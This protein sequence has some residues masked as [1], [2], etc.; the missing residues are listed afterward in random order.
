[1]KLALFIALFATTV[2]MSASAQVTALYNPATGSIALSHLDSLPFQS[3]FWVFVLKSEA[4]RLKEPGTPIGSGFT[5]H[6]GDLPGKINW[7]SSNAVLDSR[8]FNM[9]DVV[10]PGTS[11]E[12]LELKW[13]LGL[14]DGPFGVL[15]DGVIVAVPEPASWTMVASLSQV[16][17]LVLASRRLRR[18]QVREGDYFVSGC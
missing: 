5:V 17:A 6:Y 10:A 7:F 1:M 9:G 2:A 12:D 11:L 16:A 18:P 8:I 3:N 4:G 13:V 14:S 15:H